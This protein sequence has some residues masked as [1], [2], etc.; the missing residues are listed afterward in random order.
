MGAIFKMD[1]DGNHVSTGKWPYPAGEV[2]TPEW[3][4]VYPDMGFRAQNCKFR[5]CD[6]SQYLFDNEEKGGSNGRN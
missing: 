4:E 5:Y 6:L 2:H 3:G 1:E